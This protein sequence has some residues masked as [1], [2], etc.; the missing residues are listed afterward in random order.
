[1]KNVYK[2]N[3]GHLT[4]TIDR[5]E[6]TTPFAIAC[7]KCPK[8]PTL[9]VDSDDYFAKSAFYQ[10]GQHL[11]A[12]YEWYKPGKEEIK[13]LGKWE[14]EHV[15]KG[16]LIMRKINRPAPDPEV[17]PSWTRLPKELEKR[18]KGGK[19][20]TL[21][22]M[23]RSG[24]FDDYK[25]DTIV[26]EEWN[27]YC[28]KTALFEILQSKYPELSDI[29]EMVMDGSLDDKM[30]EDDKARMRRETPRALWKSLG[31]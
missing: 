8:K 20:D 7:P 17:K 15:K 2:C 26:P 4:V 18:N 19:Y 31:L 29:M 23:A 24:A 21:I 16:G 27:W 10:C 5:D 6:G 3:A 12:E 9:G 25:F 28:P 30:D 13:K 11:Q 22:L 1:M 14:K